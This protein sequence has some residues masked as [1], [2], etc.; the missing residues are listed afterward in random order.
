MTGR[1]HGEWSGGGLKI[2]RVGRTFFCRRRVFCTVGLEATAEPGARPCAPPC[3]ARDRRDHATACPAR[4]I[5][6][7]VGRQ[8]GVRFL[9]V[10][11]K[12]GKIPGTHLIDLLRMVPGFWRFFDHKIDLF[13]YGC[14]AKK[15]SPHQRLLSL[16]IR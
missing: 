11:R 3:K 12:K 9:R 2:D 1:R 16:A 7:E 8:N 15:P 14:W 10:R 4:T 6:G 5:Q 13:P